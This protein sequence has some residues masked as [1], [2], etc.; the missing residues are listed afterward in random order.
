MY[1]LT[2]SHKENFPIIGDI[3]LNVKVQVKWNISVTWKEKING[4]FV[5]SGERK[6]K[7]YTK[8]LYRIIIIKNLRRYKSCK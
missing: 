6:W 2:S 5:S 3:L 8:F 4:D 7:K 1:R